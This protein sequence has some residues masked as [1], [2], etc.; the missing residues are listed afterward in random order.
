MRSGVTPNPRLQRT[1]AAL[2]PSP[3]SRKPFGRQRRSSVTS[4]CGLLVLL[5]SLPACVIR[6]NLEGRIRELT[7]PGAAD[8]GHVRLNGD[9]SATSHCLVQAFETSRPF[10]VRYD[11]QGIDSHLETVF[12]RTQHG[13]FMRIDWDSDVTGNPI[14]SRAKPSLVQTSCSG[15]LTTAADGSKE[16]TCE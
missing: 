12:V 15:Q 5:S 9:R 3:L 13:N 6:P 16:F 11:L 8:C 2:P 7:G 14:E 10:W 4:A 1:P